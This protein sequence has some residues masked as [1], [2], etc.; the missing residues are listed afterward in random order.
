MNGSHQAFNDIKVVINDL[1]QG[2]Q[3]VGC[4]ASVADHLHV[5]RVSILV[6]AHDEHWR[7]S[8]RCRNDHLFGTALK[9]ETLKKDPQGQEY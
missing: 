8:G 7:I 3:T 4:A 9:I 6:D 2:C 5:G 1:D